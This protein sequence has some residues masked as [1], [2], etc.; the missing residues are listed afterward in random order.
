VNPGDIVLADDDG[1]VFIAPAEAQAVAEA[2][3]Q[4]AAAEAKTLDAIASRTY[5]DRWIDQALRAKGLTP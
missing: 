1:V 3:R 5:D 4:K 2:S